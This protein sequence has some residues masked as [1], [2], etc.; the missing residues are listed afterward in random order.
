MKINDLNIFYVYAYLR[1][2]DNTPYY[3]CKG[4]DK[5]AFSSKNKN[6]KVPDD[7]SKIIFYQTSLKEKDALNLEM[8]Y[9][10][11]FGRKNNETGILRNLTDGGE[12]CSGLIQS[13]YQRKIA[14][15]THKSKPK[16][17]ETKNKISESNIGKHKREFALNASKAAK[18][19]NTGKKR[20][21][22]SEL[23]KIKM[24]KLFEEGILVA[25]KGKDSPSYGIKRSEETKKLIGKNSGLARLGKKRGPYKK[26]VEKL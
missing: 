4:K 19:I 16:T 1:E 10:K 17:E 25:K 24:K 12:G 7:K 3:I 23:M 9:I 21:E 18:L 15:Q 6:V 8:K 11:L 5:R 13:N 20:P 26:K 2:L 14:S 22:H